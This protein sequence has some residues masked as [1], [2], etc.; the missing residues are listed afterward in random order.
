M[1]EMNR[2]LGDLF[3][4]DSSNVRRSLNVPSSNGVSAVKRAINM[5]QQEEKNREETNQDRI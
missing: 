2:T 3:G 1:R 5:G 4:Y